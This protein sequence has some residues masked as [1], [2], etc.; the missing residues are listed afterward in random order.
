MHA[1]QVALWI[2]LFSLASGSLGAG[3]EVKSSGR[4]GAPKLL[5][6]V[7]ERLK[8][9]QE[10][11]YA[12]LLAEITRD[13]N[14]VKDP[15]NWLEF[16]S[17]SGPSESFSLNFLDSFAQGEEFGSALNAWISAHP[18]L[19]RSQSLLLSFTTEVTNQFVV[20]RDDLGYR[21]DN[22]DFSKSR[23]LRVTVFRV[24]A[25]HQNE[26][27]E[28]AKM[29]KESFEKAHSG[30]AWV[31]Y[32][33]NSGAPG[34]EF[35]ILEP[36]QSLKEADDSFARGTSLQ[37]GRDMEVTPEL[38]QIAREAFISVESTLYVVNAPQS[39]VSK[40]F[41]AGDPDFWTPATR[42]AARAR[43]KPAGSRR[44]P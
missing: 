39:H 18:G 42:P 7:H 26:F 23:L 13:Y 20:R 40:E 9:G 19:L 44:A 11:A 27:I 14:G 30:D 41:A 5:N 33:L 28:A 24:R 32:E 22:I 38:R 6:I 2:I 35:I 17:I 25:G 4:P 10:G 15:V 36:M 16:S 21:V 29:L 8:P 12:A 31:V 3:Q 34:P 37:E 43:K 1:R